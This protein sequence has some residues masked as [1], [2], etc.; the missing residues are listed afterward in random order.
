M[1]TAS[2]LIDRI[3]AEA[4]MN[5]TA[6]SSDR[7]LI[8]TWLQAAADRS[9]AAAEVPVTSEA[10]VTLTAGDVTYTLDASP[11][12][13]DMIALLDV[14]VSD[15]AVNLSPVDY[16]TPHEM[17]GMRVGGS[18]AAQGTPQYYSGDW[19]NFVCWPPPGAGTTL[20]ITYMAGAPTLTDA[21]TAISVIPPHCV[22]GCW[23][24]LAMWRAKQYKGDRDAARDHLASYLTDRDAGLPALR[25]WAGEAMSR[26]GPAKPR[27]YS[28]VFSP[29]QDTGF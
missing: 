24:E 1:A 27:L 28:K 3:A 19:P 21:T 18:S 20:A 16:V 7:A 4:K 2:S 5:G 17:Q 15:S 6:A 11:F 14:S 8:L 23:Y 13:T 12:P 26:Q 25:R 29:S 22:E 9:C 10:S